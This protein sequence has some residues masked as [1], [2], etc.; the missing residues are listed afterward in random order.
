VNSGQFHI[1]TSAIICQDHLNELGHQ[2]QK[3]IDFVHAM[4]YNAQWTFEFV[5]LFLSN[6]AVDT[7]LAAGRVAEEP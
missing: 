2:L 3:S 7:L 5:N 6:L 1:S 4:R